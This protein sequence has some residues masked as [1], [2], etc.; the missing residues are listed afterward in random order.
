MNTLAII[1]TAGRGADQE[2]LTE[3]HWHDMCHK[4]NLLCNKLE[5]EYGPLALVSGGA[6][7]ADHAAVAAHCWRPADRPLTIWFPEHEKDIKTARWYHSLFS[8]TIGRDTWDDF[9]EL[10]CTRHY[11]GGFLDRNV[12]VAESANY[13]L[14]MTFGD[15]ERVKDGGTAHTVRKMQERGIPGWHLD[16][17]T[18][19]MYKIP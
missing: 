18:F 17:N 1:G 3:A 7:W 15:K 11:H 5:L 8:E 14:A 4:A 19:K 2:R 10:V 6:A 9:D 16:L 13:F 12:K